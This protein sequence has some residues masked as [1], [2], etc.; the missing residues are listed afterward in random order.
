MHIRVQ[1]VEE[2][3]VGAWRHKGHKEITRGH[4]CTGKGATGD[5]VRRDAREV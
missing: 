1:D 5:A 4:G 2:A 3:Q